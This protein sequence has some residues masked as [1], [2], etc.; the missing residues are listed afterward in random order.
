MKMARHRDVRNLDADDY[1]DDSYGSS[2]GSSYV[3]ETSLSSSMENYLYR[4]SGGGHTPK[5]SHFV[6]G[7][8]DSV[9]S[10][11]E[12]D[13]EDDGDDEGDGGG[14]GGGVRGRRRDAGASGARQR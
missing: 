14:G 12:E 1:N 3:E 2:Y 13:G 11:P 4:R 6:L 8:S 10:V 7:R 9:P 5:M